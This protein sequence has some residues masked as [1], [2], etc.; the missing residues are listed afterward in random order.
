MMLWR[1]L[2][3]LLPWRRRAAERDM[4][5]ELQSIAGMAGRGELGNLTLAAEDARAE[6]GWTRLEQTVQDLRYALRTLARSPGFTATAVLS[7]ALGIGANTALF[8]LINAVTWRMLPVREPETLFL[9][10]ERQGTAISNGFTYQQYDM[11]RDHNRVL[12][13]PAYS[14]ARL[15]ISIDGRAEPTSEGELV[16]G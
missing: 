10:G 16:P 14:R 11:I 9:L 13:L 8:T 4:R 6:W 3:F 2:A 12:D 7:L 15:N 5:E 1:R